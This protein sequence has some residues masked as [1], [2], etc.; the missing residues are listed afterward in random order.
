MVQRFSY[1]GG[2]F[3]KAIHKE[4]SNSKWPWEKDLLDKWQPEYIFLKIF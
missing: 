4:F 1:I 2:F 3:G